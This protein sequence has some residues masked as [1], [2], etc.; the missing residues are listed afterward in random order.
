M[1]LTIEVLIC[2]KLESELQNLSQEDNQSQKV[3]F[4][5]YLLVNYQMMQKLQIL[6]KIFT[7]EVLSRLKKKN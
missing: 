2:I 7:E 1:V 3:F 4:G 6:K 5:F